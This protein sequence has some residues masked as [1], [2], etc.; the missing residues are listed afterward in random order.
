MLGNDVDASLIWS[1]FITYNPNLDFANRLGIDS[2]L[3]P[4]VGESSPVGV[5]GDKSFDVALVHFP[6]L[7]SNEA[8]AALFPE[9]VKSL[10]DFLLGEGFSVNNIGAA[11]RNN[12]DFLAPLFGIT[13]LGSYLTILWP[14]DR[15]TFDLIIGSQDPSMTV[16]LYLED[17]YVSNGRNRDYTID[18]NYNSDPNSIVQR[19]RLCVYQSAIST[20]R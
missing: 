2:F 14:Y 8:I 20:R 5:L 11:I 10:I 13:E 16:D 18:E 15:A 19:T 6:D 17:F 4:V 1:E 12:F 3:Q 9:S 7:P